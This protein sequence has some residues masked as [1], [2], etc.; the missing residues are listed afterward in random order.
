MVS[1]TQKPQNSTRMV[2]LGVVVLFHA[3]VGLAMASGLGPKITN[4]ITETEVAII[5]TPPEVEDL[6]PPPPP[7]VDFELPPPPPQVVLP[8]IVF[9]TPPPATAITQVQQVERPAPPPPRPAAPAPAP[10]QRVMPALRRGA[11]QPEYPSASLRLEEEGPTTLEL[12]VD[13][14]GRVGDAKVVSSSGFPRLDEAALKWV[15]RERFNAGTEN[16]QRTA[17]CG[18]RLTYEWRVERGR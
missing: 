9:D 15:R 12:C 18:F 6:P 10:V 2:G 1:Y 17:M 11:E 4:M 13:E 3:L 7:P 5:D 8:S 14:N 16:G